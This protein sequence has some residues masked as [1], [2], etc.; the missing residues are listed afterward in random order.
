MPLAEARGHQLPMT[1]H[2]W[3]VGVIAEDL[4][5]VESDVL[6]HEHEFVLYAILGPQCPTIVTLPPS[7]L[8]TSGRS[9]TRSIPRTQLAAGQET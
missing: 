5:G 7:T 2:R 9:H 6:Q 4:D 1:P 3:F 8:S